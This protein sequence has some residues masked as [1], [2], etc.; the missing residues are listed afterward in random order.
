MA[1]TREISNNEFIQI[2][3]N[4]SGKPLYLKN[5]IPIVSPTTSTSQEN[6]KTVGMY[7]GQTSNIV[8]IGVTNVNNK[9]WNEILEA[10]SAIPVT[11]SGIYGNSI[12][13]FFRWD[14][15]LNSYSNMDNIYNTGI[16]FRGNGG[17]VNFGK[18]EQIE[19][20][21][22]ISYIPDWIIGLLG[23]DIQNRLGE[24]IV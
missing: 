1:A 12:D 10:N 17:L 5:G 15:R 18:Y 8:I 7:T 11:F 23:V 14:E 4:I 2:I 20:I 24:K 9:W 3:E 13:Y 16:M 6:G 21:E 19:N 22:T